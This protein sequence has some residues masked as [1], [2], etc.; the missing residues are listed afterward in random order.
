MGKVTV[1][2]VVIGGAALCAA[3]ALVVPHR[4]QI[5]KQCVK[6]A[7][8]F[9]ISIVPFRSLISV[10]VI[11]DCDGEGDGCSGGDWRCSGVCCS[12]VGCATPDADIKT[13]CEIR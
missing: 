11:V 13:M 2:V 6:S 7:D 1:A 8:C 12:G 9:A 5:S 4:M 10:S 3:A